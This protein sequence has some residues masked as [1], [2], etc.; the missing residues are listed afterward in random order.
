MCIRDSHK[1]D[2]VILAVAQIIVLC[3]IVI[4]ADYIAVGI[5][6]IQ[7]LHLVRATALYL[8]LIHISYDN[9][10]LYTIL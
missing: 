4:D 6:G 2:Y 9:D 10:F 7:L 1:A 8:S 3:S 5:V